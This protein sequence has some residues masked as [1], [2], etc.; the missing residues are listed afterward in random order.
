VA[1]NFWKR[2]AYWSGLWVFGT[3]SAASQTRKQCSIPSPC[4]GRRLGRPS[5]TGYLPTRPAPDGETWPRL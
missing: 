3:S 2:A 4:H 5:L 1:L